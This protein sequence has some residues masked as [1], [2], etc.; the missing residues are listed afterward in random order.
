MTLKTALLRS[1]YALSEFPVIY[2]RNPLIIH[3]PTDSP[4]CTLP[5]MMITFFNTIYL[6]LGLYKFLSF[7][8]AGKFDKL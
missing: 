8:G 3:E 5:V 6:S 4:G 7:Q 1:S 2:R